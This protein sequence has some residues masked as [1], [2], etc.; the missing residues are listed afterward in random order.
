MKALELDP[1]TLA[2]LEVTRRHSRAAVKQLRTV[3]RLQA[4]LADRLDEV[5]AQAIAQPEEAQRDE[6]DEEDDE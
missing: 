5:A 3:T 2:L 6:H 4:Q 1:E